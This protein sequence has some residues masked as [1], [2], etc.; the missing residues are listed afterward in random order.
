MTRDIFV[1]ARADHVASLASAAPL[2]ALEE[3]I[4]NALD[5]DAREVRIDLVQNP[6]GG[7]D[8]VRVSDDGSGIDI[9]RVE[10]TFGSL[11][12]SWKMADAAKTAGYG[13]RLHGRH[14]RGRFK[15]FAL[16]THVAWRTTMK[17]G[18]ELLSYT[19]SGDAEQPGV[20]HVEQG[21]TGAATGTEVYVTGVRATVD[22]LTVPGP[23]VQALA[24]KF[25]LY[26][27]AY[28]DVRIYF[29]GIPVSPVIV[30]K[31]AA[32]YTVKLENGQEAKLEVIEWRKKFS[33][34]GRIVFCGR[35]GFSLHERP[36]GVR[37]GQPFSYTAYV[38]G[39]RFAE[40]AGENAL[41]MDE[42]HPEVRAWIDAT[43]KILKEHFHRRAAEESAARLA[44]WIAEKSYP[45]AADDASERRVRFDAGVAEMRE[46]LDGFDALPVAERTYLFN[47]LLKTV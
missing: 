29:C 21:E 9:L 16:G 27:K 14:G 11:G 36:S 22:S 28:P 24:A 25:A 18:G 41:V 4:W 45:F 2:S 5:A 19:L 34:K 42:L 43:R 30:Q 26:L 3:L 39:A 44:K 32:E 20:F 23:A 6:L 7:V 1:Q 15:A 17:A 10:E 47:L 31:H 13:R 38:Q 40:L 8:A 33:G 37:S 12:G 46:A 35:D